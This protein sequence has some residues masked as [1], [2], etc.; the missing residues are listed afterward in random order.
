[1][2]ES[3]NDNRSLNEQKPEK[4]AI[5]VIRDPSHP[6]ASPRSGVVPPVETRF[7][8]GDGRQRPGRPA[9]SASYKN[10]LNEMQDWDAEQLLSLIRSKRGP[11]LK[12]A[13]A[14]DILERAFPGDLAD[15]ELVCM[16]E[17]GLDEARARG[18]LTDRI[19]KLKTKEFTDKDGNTSTTREVELKDDAN[20]ALDRVLDRTGG[21]PAQEVQLRHS[22]GV[23]L[24]ILVRVEGGASGL[25][26]APDVAG[27]LPV[28]DGDDGPKPAA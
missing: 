7:R 9:A 6:E 12:I 21:K 10:W 18:L 27:R 11:A 17:I 23:D 19:K 8:P 3:A 25:P 22:G 1:M 4:K 26:P 14:R 15:F 13:A 2:N 5:E 20:K 16:G 24:G 28:V